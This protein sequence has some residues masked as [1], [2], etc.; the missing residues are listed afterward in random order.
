MEQIEAIEVACPREAEMIQ[1]GEQREI[2]EKTT[3]ALS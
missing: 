3:S 2:H 1:K